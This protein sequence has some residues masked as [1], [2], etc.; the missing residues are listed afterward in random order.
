MDDDID[1]EEHDLLD[2]PAMRNIF[3]DLSVVKKELTGYFEEASTINCQPNTFHIDKL[4]IPKNEEHDLLPDS[5]SMQTGITQPL[6]NASF[7]SGVSVNQINQTPFKTN[8][9]I[10]GSKPS[11]TQNVVCEKADRDVYSAQVKLIDIEAYI[12]NSERFCNICLILFPEK[13]G[14]DVH[15]TLNHKQISLCNMARKKNTITIGSVV[16]KYKCVECGEI[17]TQHNQLRRH[18]INIHRKNH[19]N[20]WTARKHITHQLSSTETKMISETES[21]ECFHCKVTFSSKKLLI[22]HIYKVLQS[23][24]VSDI[25]GPQ[26]LTSLGKLAE[27]KL[28]NNLQVTKRVLSKEMGDSDSTHGTKIR[29]I[30]QK[31]Y[32]SGQRNVNGIQ[33]NILIFKC[34]YCSYN[35]SLLKFCLSHI[36][37]KHKDFSLKKIKPTKFNEQCDH[38]SKKLVDYRVYNSHL[39]LYHKEK[40]EKTIKVYPKLCLPKIDIIMPL[41][42]KPKVMTQGN[43]YNN[44]TMRSLKVDH[45]ENLD[46]EGNKQDEESYSDCNEQLVLKSI[47]FKCLRCDIHFLSAKTAMNHADHMELLINWKCLSCNKIFKKVDEKLHVRQHSFSDNFTVYEFSETQLSQLLYKCSKCAIHF[48]ANGFE[49]HIKKCEIVVAES[50][51]CKICDILIDRCIAGTHEDYHHRRKFKPTDFTILLS[52]PIGAESVQKPETIPMVKKL[53]KKKIKQTRDRSNFNLKYCQ[54]CNSFIRMRGVKRLVHLESRCAHLPVHICKICGLTFTNKSMGAHRAMHLKKKGIK[55]QDFTF[56]CFRKN[57]QISPPVPKYPECKNCNVHFISKVAVL[58]HICSEDY[59]TCH[60]CNIKLSEAVFKLHLSFHYYS[61]T[62][63]NK[64]IILYQSDAIHSGEQLEVR[65]IKRPR[66]PPRKRNLSEPGHSSEAEIQEPKCSARSD[67]NLSSHTERLHEGQGDEYLH[68]NENN[69]TIADVKPEPEIASEECKLTSSKHIIS[70]EKH[71]VNQKAGQSDFVLFEVLYCCT[72]CHITIDTYDKVVEHCQDHLCGVEIEKKGCETCKI[73]LDRNSYDNHIKEFHSDEVTRKSFKLLEF[74]TF[75]FTEDNKIWTKHIFRNISQEKSLQILRRSIYR[76]GCKTKMQVIQDGSPDLTVYKCNSCFVIVDPESVIKH[77][78]NSCFKSRKHPC[79]YCGLPFMSYLSLKEHLSV[80]KTMNI[81]L[82]SY[83]IVLINQEKDKKSNKIINGHNKFFLLYKCRKCNCI[84]DQFQRHSHTLCSEMDL[85]NCPV[86]GLLF[87]H[88]DYKL[89]KT[90]HELVYNFVPKN[91]KIILFGDRA[92]K[93]ASLDSIDQKTFKGTIVDFTF[94][95]C[96]KC[97]VCLEKSPIT[98]INHIKC[99]ED[100]EKSKCPKCEMYVL[101]HKFSRHCKL[102]D[103]NVHFVKENINIIPYDHNEQLKKFIPASLNLSNE[104]KNA[105]QTI[106]RISH[107][108]KEKSPILP[109]KTVKLF[110]C[111]CGL[112]YLDKNGIDEHFGH[113]NPKTSKQYCSKCNLLFTPSVLFTH[114]LLHHGDKKYVYKYNI[115]EMSQNKNLIINIYNCAHCRTHF[116]EYDKALEHFG[117]CEDV[118]VERKECIKCKVFFPIE[119]IAE[120]ETKHHNES[121]ADINIIDVTDKKDQNKA[122]AKSIDNVI[123]QADIVRE[124]KYNIS[125]ESLSQ[126]DLSR[127]DNT[128]YKCEPCN[129]HFLTEHTL[130]RHVAHDRHVLSPQQTCDFCKLSFSLQSLTK[131]IY[132]HHDRM[133]INKNEF[134]IKTN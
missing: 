56:Y 100:N 121:V 66:P 81:T 20:N 3:P 83:R 39:R 19:K 36:E 124:T 6:D 18:L 46:S 62:N 110:K 60:I 25:N 88:S 2:N 77:V 58:N 4:I 74:D 120:H 48:N 87:Y 22:D 14:L 73:T 118:E 43:N 113:C 8:K 103:I 114:L 89:H 122:D 119:S 16:R 69:S 133:K 27:D 54:T 78:E 41:T 106:N 23:K 123:D 93:E 59:L 117:N 10:L 57:K 130:R 90:K 95:Q 128:I 102:H 107:Q 44:L 15:T 98:T 86:C 12:K 112:H 71:L 29:P 131:H 70:V 13:E 125:E 82:K 134:I 72:N 21:H 5:N 11:L 35:F 47:L 63:K 7:Q 55:L 115:I 111:T 84:L 61:I 91:M 109:E 105:N 24:Q 108:T 92:S 17:F 9:I 38:C 132:I 94:I 126:I 68:E 101:K 67:R 33:K 40:I 53:P 42:E 51:Y 76:Y 65:E 99:Y 50:V 127:Y 79:S 97:G 75:Y 64:K 104:A 96:S 80:H 85:K 28:K 52:E 116:I 45:C 31:R 129:T 26:A 1:I 49:P 37:N 30:R 34:I 32:E